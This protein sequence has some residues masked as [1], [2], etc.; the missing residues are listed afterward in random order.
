MKQ[1][2]KILLAGTALGLAGFGLIVFGQTATSGQRGGPPS[3]VP[4]KVLGPQKGFVGV[5][6]LVAGG[7]TWSVRVDWTLN[8]NNQQEALYQ[9]MTTLL[10]NNTTIPQDRLNYYSAVNNPPTYVISGWGGVLTNV[11]QQGNGTYL[12]TVSVC[13][14]FSAAALF[15]SSTEVFTD[16]SEQYS[17][18]ANNSLSYVGFLDPKGWAGQMPAMMTN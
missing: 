14:F 16:Y 13:P 12:L 2:K 8:L 5:A 7:N 3:P 6:P 9:Q 15:G 10:S 1:P 11:Q 4:K 18:D 17:V